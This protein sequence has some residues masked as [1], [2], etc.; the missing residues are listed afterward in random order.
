MKHCN[1][2]HWHSALVQEKRLSQYQ[3]FGGDNIYI[4][5]YDENVKSLSDPRSSVHGPLTGCF[6]E[7]SIVINNDI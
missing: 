5:K 1:L 4:R 7:L 3:K 2:K 6:L